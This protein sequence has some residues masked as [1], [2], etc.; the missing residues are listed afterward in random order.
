MDEPTRLRLQDAGWVAN[1]FLDGS[2]RFMCSWATTTEA[3]D[4]LGEAL[5]TLR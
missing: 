5:R 1:R 2:V 4:A 3:V